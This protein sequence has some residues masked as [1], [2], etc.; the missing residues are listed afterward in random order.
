MENTYLPYKDWVR[1][2]LE[3][4]WLCICDTFRGTG[5]LA[6]VCQRIIDAAEETGIFVYGY[7]R[8]F[9]INMPE[10]DN[11]T[12]IGKWI[13][14]GSNTRIENSLKKNRQRSKTLYQKY[15]EY[16]FCSFD[17]TGMDIGDRWFKKLAFGYKST[18]L[19]SGI[20]SDFVDH[21]IKC[22]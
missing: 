18:K 16:G 19:K 9:Q 17:G 4:E 6:V 10:L 20:V 11:K 5:H 2:A 3:I 14:E 21:H 1:E 7:A 22:I 8:N 15:L 12:D 13:S